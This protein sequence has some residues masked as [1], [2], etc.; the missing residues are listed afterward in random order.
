MSVEETQKKLEDFFIE[1][2]EVHGAT[3]KG[4]DCSGEQA[5]SL[6]F[7]ELIRVIDPSKPFTVIDYG[8]GYGGMF[9]FLNAKGWQFE[10][11]GVDI[12]E[13]M[14]IAGREAHK[15]HAR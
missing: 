6:R 12:I 9:D 10:Y 13:K 4:V 3:A 1:K 2:L 8:S 11:Y 15:D 7:A 14:V 5:Q